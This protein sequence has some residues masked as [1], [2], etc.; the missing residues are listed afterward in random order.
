MN[1]H[2]L[3]AATSSNERT[4]PTEWKIIGSTFKKNKKLYNCCPEPYIDITYTL[5]FQRNHSSFRLFV[6]FPNI[7]ECNLQAFLP[8]VKY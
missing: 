3:Q 6:I 1:F 7:G 8:N 2:L 4:Y 5:T